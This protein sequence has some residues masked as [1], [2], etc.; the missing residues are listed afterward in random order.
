MINYTNGIFTR[1][2]SQDQK[3]LYASFFP[4]VI[5]ER[6]DYATTG[7]FLVVLLHPTLGLETFYLKKTDEGDIW[8]VDE[9]SGAIVEDELIEWCSHQIESYN[10]KNQ[11]NHSASHV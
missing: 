9:N 7:R 10:N 4:E 3:K 5:I 1:T 6:D 2:Y 11:E 8:E